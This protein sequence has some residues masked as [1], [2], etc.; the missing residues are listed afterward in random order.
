M[1]AFMSPCQPDLVRWVLSFI[2]FI[3][4]GQS[5]PIHVD[6]QVMGCQKG[7]VVRACPFRVDQQ[8]VG[9]QKDDVYLLVRDFRGSP[10][11]CVNENLSW[12]LRR[13]V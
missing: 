6:Q 5:I 7:V 8:V 12:L 2:F 3:R 11:L 10:V 1:I 13:A 9:C 4:N